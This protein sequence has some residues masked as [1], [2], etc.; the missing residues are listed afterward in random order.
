MRIFL[1]ILVCFFS[2]NHLHGQENRKTKQLSGRIIEIN[3]KLPIH[4]AVIL[5]QNE[6]NEVLA[7]TESD[8]SGKFS[9][10]YTFTG[11]T[12]SIK[13]KL[14]G[15]NTLQKKISTSLNF[16]E[17]NLVKAESIELKE[18]VIQNRR[19]IEVIGDTVDYKIDRFTN[20]TEK[21]IIDVLAK[22]PGI[23]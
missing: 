18:V 10:N 16:F 8:S 20:G 13:V 4:H 21:N 2:L 22:L 17:G 9:I 15:F 19:S 23:F 6:S 1:L 7:F 3:S 14:L 11:D 5:I 12:I